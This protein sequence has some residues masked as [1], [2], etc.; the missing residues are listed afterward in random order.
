MKHT[1]HNIHLADMACLCTG[2]DGLLNGCVWT[3]LTAV[4]NRQINTP[5]A[6]GHTRPTS[7]SQKTITAEAKSQQK[8][9]SP[10]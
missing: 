6:A 5:D 4:M 10:V 7:N 3:V 1:T 8:N 2:S 9:T